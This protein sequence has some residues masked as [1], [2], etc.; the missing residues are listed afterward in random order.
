MRYWRLWLF[1]AVWVVGG[2]LVT[3]PGH[4]AF[5]G[6]GESVSSPSEQRLHAVAVVFASAL[7]VVMADCAMR[8]RHIRWV[9]RRGG[10]VL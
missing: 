8:I 2:S 10:K 4:P 7:V 9:G 6:F 5:A 3:W 1:T